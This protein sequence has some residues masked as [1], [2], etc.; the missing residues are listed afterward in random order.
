MQVLY[1]KFPE[2]CK[3][4]YVSYLLFVYIYIYILYNIYKLYG[5]V[6]IL[7][8]HLDIALSDQFMACVPITEET[9]LVFG[10]SQRVL[11]GGSS[12]QK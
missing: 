5:Y 3:N 8:V 1:L 9:P 4:P 2:I 10:N 7:Y 12:C 11:G 6:F